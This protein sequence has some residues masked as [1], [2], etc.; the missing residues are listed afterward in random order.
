[1]QGGETEEAELEA[2]GEECS[3][4]DEEVYFCTPLYSLYLRSLKKWQC[5]CNIMLLN[6]N[7]TTILEEPASS[8]LRI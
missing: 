4:D 5:S 1:L 2:E 8:S 6:K 7:T 3:S